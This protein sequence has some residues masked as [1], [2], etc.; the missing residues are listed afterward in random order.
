MNEIVVF[1][2]V[3]WGLTILLDGV[4]LVLLLYRKNH[5]VFPVF[6][7]YILLNVLQ[8][9]ALVGIYLI[10]GF[11]SPVSKALGWGS[12]SIV[13]A[14]RAVAVAQLCQRVLEE[15]RGIWALAKRLLVVTA[16]VVLLCSW[17]AARGSWQL[18]LLN[19][20]RGLELSIASVIVIFFVFTRYYGVPVEPAVRALAIGFFLLS[21]FFVLNDTILERMMYGYTTLWNLLGTLAFLASLLLWT[22]TLREWQPATTLEPDLLPRGIYY[23]V[24]PEIDDRLRALNEHLGHFWNVDRKRS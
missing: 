7:L 22:W 14:A 2:R 16:A 15:Y 11:D 18:A 17:A 21:C 9:F 19:S 5:R 24:A 12:Q 3:L 10:W 20:D 1:E 4:L 6:F 8:G 13:L 23:A